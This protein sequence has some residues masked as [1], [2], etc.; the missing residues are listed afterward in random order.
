MQTKTVITYIP[1]SNK[2]SFVSKKPFRWSL[3]WTYGKFVV[4]LFFAC[5]YLIFTNQTSTLGYTLRRGLRAIEQAQ[6]RLDTIQSKV[7]KKEQELRSQVNRTP[8]KQKS[9]IVDL[10]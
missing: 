5:V 6:E 1:R 7:S 10:P 3:I 9:L 2:R 8:S 4:V